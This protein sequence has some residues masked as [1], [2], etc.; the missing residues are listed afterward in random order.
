MLVGL[1]QMYQKP[2]W[3]AKPQTLAIQSEQRRYRR[4]YSRLPDRP[5][6]KRDPLLHLP[7]CSE[8]RQILHLYSAPNIT[9]ISKTIEQSEDGKPSGCF[10]STQSG[11]AWSGANQGHENTWSKIIFNASDSSSLYGSSTVQPP[12]IALLPCIKF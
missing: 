7:L 11:T 4:P 3:R 10:A 1:H 6:R 5:G 12:S 8:Q 9:G 2:H